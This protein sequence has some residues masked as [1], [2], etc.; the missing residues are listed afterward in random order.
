MVSPSLDPKW[1]DRERERYAGEGKASDSN[2]WGTTWNLVRRAILNGH[3]NER[4][5]SLQPAAKIEAVSLETIREWHKRALG[6]NG[7]TITVAGSS[8]FEGIE[9]AIDKALSGLPKETPP[10]V[11]PFDQLKVPNKTVVFHAPW[12]EKSTMLSLGELPNSKAGKDLELNISTGVLGYG[13]QSRL[14]K[15]IRSELRAT[16]GFRAGMEAF[17]RK[18]RILNMGGEVET[19][20]PKEALDATKAAYEEFRTDGIGIIE[21]PFARRFYGQRIDGEMEKP[22]SVAY[23]LMESRLDGRPVDD[24]GTMRER[25]GNLERGAVNTFIAKTYPPFDDMLKIIV[26]PK[27]DAIADACVISS[28]DEFSI[29]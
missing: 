3:S 11:Q 10:Q 17:T 28:Y 5:W 22:E 7:L 26:T 13:E 27:A 23:M 12:A 2:V 1:F 21:F 25:I 20:K 14:F 24:I 29:C 16:Y 9:K 15:A 8:D 18:H 6:T 19:E 4:F